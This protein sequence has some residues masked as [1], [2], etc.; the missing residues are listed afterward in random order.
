VAVAETAHDVVTERGRCACV[1]RSE[2][3]RTPHLG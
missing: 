3:V 2:V 1:G